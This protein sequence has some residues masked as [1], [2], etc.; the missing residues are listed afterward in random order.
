[1]AGTRILNGGAVGSPGLV[2]GKLLAQTCPEGNSWVRFLEHAVYDPKATVAH[3]SAISAGI[4]GVLSTAAPAAL[5][6]NGGGLIYD[7]VLDITWAQ[8]DSSGVQ[9]NDA[10][11]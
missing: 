6:D 8:S 5:V 9:C 4:L 3:R 10:N 11:A 7:T 2:N 1:M